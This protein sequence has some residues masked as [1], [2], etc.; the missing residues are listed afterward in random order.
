[1]MHPLEGG[2]IIALVQYCTPFLKRL[3]RSWL[4]KLS[5]CCFLHSVYLFLLLNW[6]I[7]LSLDIDGNQ[8]YIYHI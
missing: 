1:M 6:Q 5:E 3:M 4:T 7:L 2:P 8:A